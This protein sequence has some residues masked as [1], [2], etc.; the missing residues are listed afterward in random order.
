MNAAQAAFHGQYKAVWNS[1][2][3]VGLLI[4]TGA[5]FG[6]GGPNITLS[7]AAKPALVLSVKRRLC[8]YPINNREYKSPFP[9]TGPSATVQEPWCWR[10]QQPAS[11]GE[12]FSGHFVLIGGKSNKKQLFFGSNK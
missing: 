5:P 4:S 10:A 11:F 8:V 9:F 3:T 7:Q 2:K 6:C 1:G 12:F